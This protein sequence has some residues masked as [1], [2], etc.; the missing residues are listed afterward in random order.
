MVLGCLYIICLIWVAFTILHTII[1]TISMASDLLFRCKASSPLGVDGDRTEFLCSLIGPTCPSESGRLLRST[2][3][4]SDGPDGWNPLCVY[5]EKVIQHTCILHR[6]KDNR[7]TIC[8]SLRT[9][10][11]WLSTSLEYK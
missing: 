5:R 11:G 2:L 9:L 1:L 10:Q 3:S 4:S 8:L 6:I 7:F